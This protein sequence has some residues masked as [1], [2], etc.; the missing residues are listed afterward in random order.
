MTTL[1]AETERWRLVTLGLELTGF[2]LLF[3]MLFVPAAYQPAKA[4]L[5]ALLMGALTLRILTER[6]IALHPIVAFGCLF[7]SALGVAFILRGYLERAP[8]AIRMAT[9]Y[10]VWPCVYTLLVTG[11]AQEARLWRLARLLVWATTAICLYCASYILWAAGWLPDALYLSL[12][13][14][15]R[16]GFYDGFMEFSINSMS[17]LLFLVPFVAAALIAWPQRA[18]IARVWLWLALALGLVMVLLSGRR[19]FQLT[20]AT[21]VPLALM[22]WR[23]LPRDLRAARGSSVKR[24]LVGA[25]VATAGAVMALQATYGLDLGVVWATFKTGFQFTGDLVAQSRATQF[26]AL[27]DGWVSSPL[28][29]SG[30]GAAAPGVIRSPTMP[31]AYELS[32]VALLFHTGVVGLALYAL[33]VGWIYVEGIRAIR[34]GTVLSPLMVA[35]L[36]GTSTFLIANATNPYLE[37]FD[38]LWTLFLPV[39]VINASLLNQDQSASGWNRLRGSKDA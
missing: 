19:A 9:V 5:L 30:H 1:A 20:L 27:I 31:W 6:R 28:F 32:Y 11:L 39:A 4:A 21:T 26:E 17:S 10:V 22:F 36:T 14:H 35:V 38:C 33:G 7:F 18:V 8:G 25:A 24:S 2:T 16:V 3:L 13:L 15:Q 34:R 23:L 37:K 12:D 29:G